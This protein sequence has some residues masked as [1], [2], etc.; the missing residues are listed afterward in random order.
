MYEKL[1]NA[2]EKYFAR[3]T[4]ILKKIGYNEK[5]IYNRNFHN[6]SSYSRI[7][8]RFV[9]FS[10]LSNRPDS[11]PEYGNIRLKEYKIHNKPLQNLLINIKS[12]GV[13]YFQRHDRRFNKY[14]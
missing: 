9:G 7:K 6:Y 12:S 14:I 10:I 13:D 2:S 8:Q 5:Q 11:H 1:K 4:R 3:L